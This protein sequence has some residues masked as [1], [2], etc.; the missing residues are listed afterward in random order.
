MSLTQVSV[1]KR[2]P[3]KVRAVGI[4]SAASKKY[5]WS[6]HLETII[7]LVNYPKKTARFATVICA[8]I[9]ASD[10]IAG[11]ISFSRTLY[12]KLTQNGSFRKKS[13]TTNPSR[14]KKPLMG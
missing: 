9:K 4:Y 14:S 2:L 1:G 10:D 13:Q 12:P 11:R 3:G 8:E 5:S 7:C 6:H